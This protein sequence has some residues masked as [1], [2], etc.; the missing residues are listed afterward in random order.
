[1]NQT[2]TDSCS[3]ALRETFLNPQIESVTWANDTTPSIRRVKCNDT[4][5]CR[6]GNTC[7]MTP[8]GRPSC[9]PVV[10]VTHYIHFQP[11][12]C[13]DVFHRT[14]F[15]HLFRARRIWLDLLRT[16]FDWLPLFCSRECVVVMEATA[17]VQVPDGPVDLTTPVYITVHAPPPFLQSVNFFSHKTVL[18]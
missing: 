18:V 11:N 2:I 13:F 8:S 1:M 5:N 6:E 3:K 16:V 10:M 7:C 4:H 9:C 15:T 12:S 17:A 14:F